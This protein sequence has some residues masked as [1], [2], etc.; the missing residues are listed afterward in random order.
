MAYSTNPATVESRLADLV[1]GPG[2][3]LLQ[4]STPASWSF[5]QD[6]LITQRTARQIREALA[7]AARY[8]KR[9]PELASAAEHFV[10][11]VVRDGYIEAVFKSTPKTETSFSNT[12]PIHGLEPQG[13]LVQS[14]GPAT[15]EEVKNAWQEHLPSSDALHFTSTGLDEQELYDLW[16]WTVHH[17]PRLM[18]LYDEDRATLTV[19][20]LDPTVLEFA[21]S[22]PGPAPEPAPEE[23]LNV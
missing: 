5:T 2:L 11:K 8:P 9:F 3:Q 19:S 12:S 23:R 18:M 22:P 7:I 20:L 10:I 15:A 4:Q 16:E 13:R 21:W 17:T 1:V 6:P 14:V